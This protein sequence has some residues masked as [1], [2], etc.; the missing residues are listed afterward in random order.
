MAEVAL[1]QRVD[2]VAGAAGVEHIGQQHHIV[3]G[4][5]RDAAQGEHLQIEFEVMP[6]LEHA[7]VLEQRPHRRER[8]LFG[9][10]VGR[11]LAREQAAVATIGPGPIATLT[12]RERHVASFVRRERE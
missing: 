11:D 7:R 1:R 6:D 4:R 10:L 12:V 3:I 5:K 2:A 8:V 9:N